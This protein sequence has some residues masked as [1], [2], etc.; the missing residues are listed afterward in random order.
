MY[1]HSY[2]YYVDI[3]W[4]CNV[5]TNLECSILVYA[6]REIRSTGSGYRVRSGGINLETESTM[7]HQCK[8]III[9]QAMLVALQCDEDI[10]NTAQMGI[11]VCNHEG[12]YCVYMLVHEG[13]NRQ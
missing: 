10:L 13:V 3:V 9:V 4:V 5:L 12:R 7:Y 2:K 11:T 6:M 1:T 8:H